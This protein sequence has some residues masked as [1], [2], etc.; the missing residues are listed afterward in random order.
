MHRSG[1]SAIARGLAALGVYLGDEFLEAQPENPTGYWEDKGIVDLNERI[2]K[3][4]GLQWDSVSVIE[5][6]ALDQWRIRALRRDAVRYCR[7]NLAKRPLWGFK[8][9]RTMRLLPFWQPVLRA[10]DA[11]ESYVVAIRSPRS[12]AASL[13]ARQR[14]SDEAAFQLWLAYTIPFL[15]DL[16]GKPTVVVDY[17]LLIAQPHAQLERIGARL[18]LPPPDAREVERFAAEFLD[19]RLRHTVFSPA[20]TLGEGETARLASDTYRQLHQAASDGV[21]PHTGSFWQ[22]WEDLL[23]RYTALKR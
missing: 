4:L 18:R 8:D 7:R 1:T 19:E 6:S 12:V 23:E 21:D 2:L 22:R 9:P 11:R 16:I 20:E 3:S 17:D 10:C 14:M 13:F 5:R 15:G